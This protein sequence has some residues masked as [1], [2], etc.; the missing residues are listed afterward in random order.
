MPVG[1]RALMPPA[2]PA[3]WTASPYSGSALHQVGWTPAADG[4]ML[5]V[6]TCWYAPSV[7]AIE[8]Q[9]YSSVNFADM[10]LSAPDN[11]ESAIGRSSF[12]E[13]GQP[14]HAV[15]QERPPPSPG[16]R[17]D[18]APS[19]DLPAANIAVLS[20]SV[21]GVRDRY[22]LLE[23]DLF[24]VFS[25]YGTLSNI[26]VLPAGH[27]A[28]ITF[29]E[30]GAAWAAKIDLHRKTL[31][32]LD[33]FLSVQLAEPMGPAQEPFLT[34]SSP[35][36]LHRLA[37]MEARVDDND[38]LRCLAALELDAKR[39]REKDSEPAT[40]S[41]SNDSS[42]NLSTIPTCVVCQDAP[43]C[44]VFEPCRHFAC[45]AACGGD[46]VGRKRPVLKQCPVCR[47]EILRRLDVFVS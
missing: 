25:R 38:L 11:S 24:K 31:L 40:K 4:T 43:R 27:A 2:A 44:M 10:D 39:G 41:V 15:G 36:H 19:A 28:Q 29:Q 46:E 12:V 21:E 20:V 17:R 30:Y 35:Y 16:A 33:G 42:S 14:W 45:C 6:I 3:M 32:G 1:P 34:G 22:Q 13:A 8:P 5:P 9:L 18:G 47:A 7:E 37:T 23:E 26:W